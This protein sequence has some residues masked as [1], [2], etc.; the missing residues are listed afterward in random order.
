VTKPSAP[1]ENNDVFLGAVGGE[2]PKAAEETL[3][4]P[5]KLGLDEASQISLPVTPEN[6]SSEQGTSDSIPSGSKSEDIQN[7]GEYNVDNQ[8]AEN[9][10]MA[11]ERALLPEAYRG[12]SDENAAEFW[13]RLKNYSAFKGHT[14]EQQLKLANAMLV[15]MACDWLENLE[16]AKKDTSKFGSGL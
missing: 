1:K 9:S 3:V 15:Q 14:A 7:L 4:S 6:L 8:G 5:D 16:D 10:E 11:E 2:P 13:R 12:T